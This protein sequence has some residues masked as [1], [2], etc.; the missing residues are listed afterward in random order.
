MRAALTVREIQ[1][2]LREMYTVDVSP[3][4]IST[5][6]NAIVEEITTWQARPLER[7]YAVV[8]FD[9]L[10]VKMREDRWSAAKP[11]RTATSR[12]SERH[13][14]RVSHHHSRSDVYVNDS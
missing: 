9:A 12:Q 14:S 2:F 5:V 13:A 3:V 4:F 8:F 6:T 7:V 10:R 1:A 11:S